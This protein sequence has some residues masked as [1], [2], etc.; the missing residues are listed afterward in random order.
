MKVKVK[1]TQTC[2]TF[3]DPRDC[4]VYGILWARILKW[5]AYP[6]FRGSSRPRN[7]QKTLYLDLSHFPCGSIKRGSLRAKIHKYGP[8]S[9]T[10]DIFP[11]A[12]L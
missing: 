5:V 11:A 10:D 4:I 9:F 8:V 3:C 6:F 1:V 2:P 12:S 7:I